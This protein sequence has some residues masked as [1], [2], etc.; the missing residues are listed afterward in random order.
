MPVVLCECAGH[1]Q[2]LQGCSHAVVEII[3]WRLHVRHGAQ[4]GVISGDH[5]WCEGCLVIWIASSERNRV[6]RSRRNWCCW[7]TLDTSACPASPAPLPH[8]PGKPI[9]MPYLGMTPS[10][11]LVPW[12][13]EVSGICFAALCCMKISWCSSGWSGWPPLVGWEPFFEP[14]G[15]FII[16]C[17][18]QQSLGDL[19]RQS[20]AGTQI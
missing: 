6:S 7:I 10:L 18:S 8:L 16:W 5:S 11:L 12:L 9:L 1:Q 19:I 3:L 15:H 14:G 17:N 20:T 4:A 2:G 13:S